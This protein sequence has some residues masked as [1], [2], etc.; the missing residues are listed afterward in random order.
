VD[1][2]DTVSLKPDDPT[3]DPD[4]PVDAK[5]KGTTF[6]DVVEAA[7]AA[8]EGVDTSDGVDAEEVV[9]AALDGA[10]K[11]VPLSHHA[12]SEIRRLLVPILTAIVAA[13]AGGGFVEWRAGEAKNDAIL[14]AES[15]IDQK[16]QEANEASRDLEKLRTEIRKAIIKGASWN[17]VGTLQVDED[18]VLVT[19]DSFLKEPMAKRVLSEHE[20]K[21][22]LE[23][24]IQEL[25]AQ[26]AIPPRP[27]AGH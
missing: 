22:L 8:A 13:I 2:N 18:A 19:L 4:T 10:A 16:I 7:K 15:R 24:Q 3:P 23:G 25:Q 6:V 20:L 12:I 26:S 14:E 9:D 11:I 27:T 1:G 21:A 5:A 17:D